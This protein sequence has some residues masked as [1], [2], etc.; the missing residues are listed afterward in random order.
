MLCLTRTATRTEESSSPMATGGAL[1]GAA[2]IAAQHS[3]GLRASGTVAH[4]LLAALVQTPL[5]SQA[6]SEFNSRM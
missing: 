5:Q 2:R 3:D 1:G 4:R 6:G